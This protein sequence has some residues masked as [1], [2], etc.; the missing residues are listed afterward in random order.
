MFLSRYHTIGFYILLN[1]CA[2]NVR[3]QGQRL[4]QM[5]LSNGNFAYP[6]NEEQDPAF[7]NSQVKCL[8]FL[9]NFEFCIL[10]IKLLHVHR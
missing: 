1:L 4:Q 3:C 2:I 9:E 5:A 7:Q 10:L 6:E 8:F